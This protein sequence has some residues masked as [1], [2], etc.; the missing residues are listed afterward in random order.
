MHYS[1]VILANH[2][3]DTPLFIDPVV[4]YGETAA[5]AKIK[6]TSGFVIPAIPD[7]LLPPSGA[8]EPS[9]SSG[10]TKKRGSNQANA[11]AGSKPILPDHL[12]QKMA[13]LVLE[14]PSGTTQL[15]LVDKVH[16]ALKAD[17]AKKNAV[18]A[19]LK[20]VFEKEKGKKRWIVREEYRS[21][22]GG[23]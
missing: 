17:G 19:T 16:Q 3:L 11:M 13:G 10:P 20:Q 12:V 6:D 18:E 15:L 8:S 23:A 9:T 4:T 14:A 1:Q 7:R 2:G 5:P 22:V 21:V